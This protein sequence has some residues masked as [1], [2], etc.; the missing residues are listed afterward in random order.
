PGMLWERMA[1]G[2][3]VRLNREVVRLRRTDFRIDSVIVRHEGRD[4]EHV[5]S[6]VI[7]SMPLS[8]LVLSL[9]PAAPDE[10]QADARA[11]RYR[12]FITVALVIRRRQVF[13][14]NWLY[15]HTPEVQVA[16]I[17]NYKNWSRAMVSDPE[18]TCLGM[19]YF[20]DQSHPLWQMADAELV[21]LA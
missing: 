16:R 1:R 7:A 18:T 6:D 10:I 19:E 3:D 9:E 15:I 8:E 12:D 11:L 5:G 20:C 4:E 21:A 2:Q 17:Q 13:P 14:D